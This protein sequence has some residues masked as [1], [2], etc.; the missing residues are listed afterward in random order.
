MA[1]TPVTWNDPTTAKANLT[2]D[3][4]GGVT[5]LVRVDTNNTHARGNGPKYR[6]ARYAPAASA[7]LSD[8]WIDLAT[9]FNLYTA[10]TGWALPE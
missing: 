1:A 6:S 10:V 8:N 4:A 5:V 3:A 2:L 9:G 7:G